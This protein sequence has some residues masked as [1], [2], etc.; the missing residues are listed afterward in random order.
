M[1]LPASCVFATGN[2]GEQ[3]LHR[4]P[5]QEPP[6]PQCPCLPAACTHIPGKT[7]NCTA[8]CVGSLLQIT[9]FFSFMPQGV[10]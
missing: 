6:Q 3:V 7:H 10:V 5:A 8:A 2:R 4:L 9:L 1:R